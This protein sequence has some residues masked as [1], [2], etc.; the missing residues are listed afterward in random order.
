MKPKRAFRVPFLKPYNRFITVIRGQEIKTPFL[1]NMSHPTIWHPRRDYLVHCTKS[2]HGRITIS[3]GPDKYSRYADVV[4]RK[5]MV[6]S[7]KV[8]SPNV[9]L[10]LQSVL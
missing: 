7:H 5:Q 4:P 9:N 3:C 1:W 10:K 6:K 2:V 8:H